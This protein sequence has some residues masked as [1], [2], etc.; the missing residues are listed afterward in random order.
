MK[1]IALI[2][3]LKDANPTVRLESTR[4]L[5]LVEETQSLHPLRESFRQEDDPAVQEAIDWAGKRIFAAQQRGYTTFDA[6]F[7]E[8]RLYLPPKDTRAAAEESLLRQMDDKFQADLLNQESKRLRSAAIRGAALGALAGD[9]LGL[10]GI[11]GGALLGSTLTGYSPTGLSTSGAQG[12]SN[13]RI[14]PKMPSDMQTNVWMRRLREDP[15]RDKRIQAARELVE[16]NNPSVLPKM[17]EAYLAET[18]VEVQK[19]IEGAAKLLYITEVYWELSQTDLLEKS[20]ERKMIEI[21]QRGQLPDSSQ[22]NDS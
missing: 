22:R 19:A 1:T 9:D 6:I 13:Y 18:V 21:Q 11:L 8:F 3:Q 14:P 2:N 10:P 20:I 5:G 4:V 16:L 15:S 17:A 7:A 12:S